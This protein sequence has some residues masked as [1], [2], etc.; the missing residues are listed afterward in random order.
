[1]AL[2]STTIITLMAGLDTLVAKSLKDVVKDNLGNATFEKIEARLFERNGLSFTQAVEDFEKLDHVLRE[3][4]GGGAEGIE[5]KMID[6]IVLLEKSRCDEK[7]WITMEDSRLVELLL[8]S[9]GDEDKKNII[10]SV[11][12]ESRIISDILETSNIPQTSGYRKENSLIDDGLLTPQGYTTTHDGKEVT[13]YRA[14]FENIVISI[15][16][17]KI[18]VKV[19]P[20]QESLQQSY[21]MQI[22][23]S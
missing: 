10:N 19:Q 1:M 12:N 16:K 9:L 11:M 14:I 17:N 4:F 8:K 13:K 7:K 2:S 21:I 5:R 23:C 18:V 20:T 22:V 6:K 3:L 15:E